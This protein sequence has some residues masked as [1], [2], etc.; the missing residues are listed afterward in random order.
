MKRASE[1]AA[2]RLE[3]PRKIQPENTTPARRMRDNTAIIRNGASDSF[4]GILRD[5]GGA[6]A[7]RPDLRRQPHRPHLLP[8]RSLVVAGAGQ[9][10]A[11]RAPR[12]GTGGRPPLVR[13]S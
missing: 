11:P 10:E 8:N 5:T 7:I 4:D 3:T 13:G 2:R 12:R 6:H 1:R 9:V